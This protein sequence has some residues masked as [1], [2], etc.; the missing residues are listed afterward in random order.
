MHLYIE[1]SQVVI[2]LFWCTMRKGKN[3][4]TNKSFQQYEHKMCSCSSRALVQHGK[5]KMKL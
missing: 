4:Y 3:K 2:G 1:G 5:E